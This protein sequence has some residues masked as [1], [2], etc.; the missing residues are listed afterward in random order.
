LTKTIVAKDG[1]KSADLQNFVQHHP[2]ANLRNASMLYMKANVA[3]KQPVNVIQVF[4]LRVLCLSAM[5][6]KESSSKIQKH[7]VKSLLVN[8]NHQKNAKNQMLEIWKKAK[9]LF[10]MIVVVAQNF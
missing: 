9:S 8:V 1:S 2:N 6:M 5:R 4:A 3:T 10:W 7:V